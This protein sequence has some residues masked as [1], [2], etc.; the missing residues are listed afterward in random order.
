M[1]QRL[2]D[3]DARALREWP[4]PQVAADADKEERGRVLVAGGSREIAGAVQLAAIAALRAGAGKLVIATA[5]SV[6]QHMSQVVPEARV[7]ALAETGAGSFDAKSVEAIGSTFDGVAAVLVGP[8]MMD[9]RGSVA[10]TRALL[11]RCRGIPVVLDASA[12]DVVSDL[13][14]FG[15][16]VLMTPHAGEMA[17]LLG[18]G[19][20]DVVRDAQRIACDAAAQW[21]A[22]VALKGSTTWIAT[23][24]GE[25]WRHEGESPGLATSGSG[26]VLA[27]L[28]LGFAARGVPL[29]QACAW[30][31]VMHALAGQWLARELGPLGFLARELP[32]AVPALMKKAGAPVRRSRVPKAG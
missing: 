22:V 5:R 24:Q 13:G 1:T 30:G 27:G 26:D 3:L 28:M 32:G 29:Q 21:N 8:G 6:A 25:C 14:R 17:H 31:V 10:F 15:Q 23:P 12:M 20:E 19:K 4:L 7:I 16:P 9:A 11:E 2:H 18:I